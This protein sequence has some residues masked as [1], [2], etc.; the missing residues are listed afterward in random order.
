[1]ERVKL[2]KKKDLAPKRHTFNSLSEMLTSTGIKP[3]EFA[4]KTGFPYQTVKRFLKNGRCPK[5]Y[6]VANNENGVFTIPFSRTIREGIDVISAKVRNSEMLNHRATIKEI[7]GVT[8]VVFPEPTPPERFFY[9]EAK[10]TY[11]NLSKPLSEKIRQ[12]KVDNLLNRMDRI[13]KNIN[14]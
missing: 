8:V 14:S 7:N 6:L 4:R 2:I 5:Y 9:D 12:E 10:G 11:G 3:K 13:I 1:M